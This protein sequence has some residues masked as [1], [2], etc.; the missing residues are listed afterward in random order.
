MLRQ[1][2]EIWVEFPG[3]K[4]FDVQLL[5]LKLRL[6]RRVRLRCLILPCSVGT[7]FNDKCII[8]GGKLE[9]YVTIMAYRGNFKPVSPGR[10]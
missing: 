8:S 4:L 10:L 7:H 6:P 5:R 1:R 3:V 9:V 2:S